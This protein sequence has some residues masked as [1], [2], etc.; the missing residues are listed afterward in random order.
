LTQGVAD[1]MSVFKVITQEMELEAA[2]M[3]GDI[4]AHNS[5]RH[6]GIVAHLKA[7]ELQQGNVIQIQYVTHPS[8]KSQS[9]NSRAVIR[10]GECTP[11]A[12]V[13][14]FSGVTF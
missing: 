1:F 11:F 5:E 7:L 8:F 3:G 6:D 10:T 4:Q 9:Q 13:M 12:N 14:L 2:L